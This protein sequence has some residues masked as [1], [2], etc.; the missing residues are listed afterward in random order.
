[1]MLS[2]FDLFPPS[3]HQL[4]LYLPQLLICLQDG[5]P[6]HLFYN[7]RKSLAARHATLVKDKL[8]LIP[9]MNLRQFLCFLSGPLN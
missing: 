5:S 4:L 7:Y 9:K 8:A 6:Y 1:M 2:D 3:V